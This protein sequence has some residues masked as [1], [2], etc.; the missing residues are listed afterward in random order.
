MDQAM[1]L[2]VHVVLKLDLIN[3]VGRTAKA[4]HEDEWQ[5]PKISKIHVFAKELENR[6]QAYL[7]KKLS[8]S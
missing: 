6:I 8:P 1:K 7:T 3:R 5:W 2:Q 4:K